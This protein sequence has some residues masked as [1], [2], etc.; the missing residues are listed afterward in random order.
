VRNYGDVVSWVTSAHAQIQQALA[1]ADTNP[2]AVA[3]NQSLK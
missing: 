3:N 1:P 2:A